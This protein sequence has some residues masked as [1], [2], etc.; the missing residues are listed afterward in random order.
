[1]RFPSWRSS[2]FGESVA[3]DPQH[4]VWVEAD[5]VHVEIRGHM[6]EAVALAAID[7]FGR[8]VPLDTSEIF[9]MHVH[10]GSMHKHDSAAREAW[11]R[12]LWGLRKQI[13][14]IVI[15]DGKPLQRMAAA[16]VALALGVQMRFVTTA[17][18]PA[19]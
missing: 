8:A 2:S 19:P 17:K 9:A 7:D 3:A 13:R 1:M 11:A 12:S 5:V 6:T 15:I 14:E 16:A 4:T 18:E 10:L